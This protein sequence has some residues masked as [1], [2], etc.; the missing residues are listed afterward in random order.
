MADITAAGLIE[1]YPEWT[2]AL[3]NNPL[4]VAEAVNYANS[5]SFSLYTD[6]DQERR[7][8]DLEASAWLFDHQYARAIAKPEKDTPNPYQI[9]AKK[10]DRSIATLHRAPGWPSISGI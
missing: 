10:M 7:R 8:R 9:R 2:K 5:L 1:R 4:V 6:A 3:A